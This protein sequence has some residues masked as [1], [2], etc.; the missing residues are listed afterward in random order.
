MSMS[1]A[2]FSEVIW[3]LPRRPRG[4]RGNRTGGS[5]SGPQWGRIE[6]L[7]CSDRATVQRGAPRGRSRARHGDVREQGRSLSHVLPHQR[8]RRV[9]CSTHP[10]YVLS[11]GNLTAG[12]VGPMPMNLDVRTVQSSDRVSMLSHLGQHAIPQAARTPPAESCVDGIPRSK[13]MAKI[14][15]WKSCPH[16]VKDRTRP[17]ADHLWAACRHCGILPESVF[18]RPQINFF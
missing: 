1:I 16:D 9:W 15:P 4:N 12:G 11:P 10:S 3:K 14:T 2:R 13:L 8:Q 17:P 7:I 6:H 18:A 5:Q